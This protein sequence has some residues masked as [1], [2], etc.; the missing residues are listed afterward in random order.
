M[1]AL[2][3]FKESGGFRLAGVAATNEVPS[4]ATGLTTATVVKKAEAA[5]ADKSMIG[6]TT[7]VVNVA[8]TV[9]AQE[10]LEK[11]IQ[12]AINKSRAAGNVD[13]LAPR[14]WRGEV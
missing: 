3:R 12:D 11:A 4:F 5:T 14:S 7:V 1:I 10:D 2:E 9:T 8:G 13:S 6:A